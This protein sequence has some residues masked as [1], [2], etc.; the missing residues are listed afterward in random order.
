[1]KQSLT[2]KTKL[3]ANHTII[4]L[5]ECNA[6]KTFLAKKYKCNSFHTD[7]NKNMTS[8]IV[9]VLTHFKTLKMLLNSISC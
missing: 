6:C 2:E 7:T 4:K 1:M 3:S 5:S 8:V 9:H